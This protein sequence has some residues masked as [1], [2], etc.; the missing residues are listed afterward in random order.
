MTSNSNST[1]RVLQDE[2]DFS[3]TMEA[4]KKKQ[5]GTNMATVGTRSIEL[6]LEEI[7]AHDKEFNLPTAS[8]V[9]ALRSNPGVVQTILRCH[10]C[11]IQVI[12]AELAKIDVASTPALNMNSTT[13]VN[14]VGESQVQIAMENLG[15]QEILLE[16]KNLNEAKANSINNGD[17]F[18][19]RKRSKDRRVKHWTEEE[20]NEQERLLATSKQKFLSGGE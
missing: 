1:K 15:M 3:M 13:T 5:R 18:K 9:E 14:R 20:I 17:L 16:A 2:T 10:E 8:V 4:P 6:L 7:Y 11:F 19:G 12:A